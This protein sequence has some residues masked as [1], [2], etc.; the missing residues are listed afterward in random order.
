M[1]KFIVDYPVMYTTKEYELIQE[2][3]EA[4]HFESITISNGFCIDNSFIRLNLEISAFDE[5]YGVWY[6][7]FMTTVSKDDNELAIV[8]DK[9]F[10]KLKL[11]LTCD[12]QRWLKGKFYS[13]IIVK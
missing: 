9:K 8:S 12:S 10:K 13:E 1:I 2:I 11:K 6:P 5:N 4:I 7:I 3:E